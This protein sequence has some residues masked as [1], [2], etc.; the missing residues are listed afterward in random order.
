MPICHWPVNSP[1]V[2]YEYVPCRLVLSMSAYIT[3]KESLR[4]SAALRGARVCRAL[5]V[6]VWCLVL[7]II[8]DAV[9][10]GL[11]PVEPLLRRGHHK[12]ERALGRDYLER[13]FLHACAQHHT[14]TQSKRLEA[15]RKARG[16]LPFTSVCSHVS[17]SGTVSCGMIS[18]LVTI[19]EKVSARRDVRRASCRWHTVEVWRER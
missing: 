13:W 12:H 18:P 1:P 3:Q 17:V 16:S 19:R 11:H 14:R 2:E 8:V 15:S 9:A 6:C 4:T 10:D 5:C 7:N